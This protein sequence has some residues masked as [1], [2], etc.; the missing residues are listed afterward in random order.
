MD[1]DDVKL[2]AFHEVSEVGRLPVTPYR[3]C[4][5]SSSQVFGGQVG[6]GE[7]GLSVYK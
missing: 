7:D 4:Y 5:T 3:R 1:G 6:L 2:P